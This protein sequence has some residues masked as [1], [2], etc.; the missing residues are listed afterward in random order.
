[1]VKFDDIKLFLSDPIKAIVVCDDH[2]FVYIRN[3]RTA[4]TSLYRE[5]LQ[6]RL[7]INDFNSR[8]DKKKYK[9]WLNSLTESKWN[10]Y[11]SF[12]GVRNPYDRMVSVYHYI[13]KDRYKISFDEWIL[14]IHKYD[15]DDNLFA[16]RN[17]CSERTHTKGERVVSFIYRHENINKDFNHISKII[18]IKGN[19]PHKNKTVHKHYKTYYNDKTKAVI[20]DVFKDDI[21]LLGYKF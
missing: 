14:N 13:V 17:P 11:F 3:S 8:V 5:L 6:K 16:H 7:K 21:K 18:K 1:M 2:K 15:D 12:S 10:N 20:E 19:L 4:S 9:Q